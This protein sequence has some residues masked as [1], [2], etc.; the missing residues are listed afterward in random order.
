MM[1]G[2]HFQQLL[3]EGF[4]IRPASIFDVQTAADLINAWSMDCLGVEETSPEVVH[5]DWTSPNFHL[6]EST[7]VVVSPKGELIGLME[8]WDL[9]NPPVHP[10]LWWRVH[11]AWEEDR[12]DKSLLMRAIDRA[13]QA[14]PR[15]PP[16]A[17]VAAHAEVPSVDGRGKYVLDHLE[18]MLVRHSLRMVIDL[19][20]P[21]PAPLWPEGI[22]WC[23]YNHAQ[24]AER[25]C[26][27]QE[28]AFRDHFGYVAEPFET[29]YRRWLHHAT[30]GEN[31]DPA[32]WFMA[33]DGGEI[34]GMIRGRPYLDED[35]GMGWVSALGVRRPWRRRGL[36]LA[37]LQ[38]LFAIFHQR[39]KARVGLG[40]DALSLTGATRLYRKAGM[41][42]QR[43]YDLYETTLRE[44][45][46]I[47]LMD[48]AEDG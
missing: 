3:G 23:G 17:R 45:E 21:P 24:D 44:G 27:A 6:D 22:S 13:R 34:A 35:P 47:A 48:E 40:V 4:L 39:G 7:R 8:V 9:R 19:D 2:H 46:E 12:V 36:G 1:A 11:P 42:V 20:T 43:Q 32:L 26:R 28:E 16:G 25:M 29:G 14:I 41:H 33:M 31:F 30:E 5:K 15:T 38:H 10:F 18:F 37:L